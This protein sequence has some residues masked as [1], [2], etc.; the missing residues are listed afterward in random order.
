MDIHMKSTDPELIEV[1]AKEGEYHGYETN[2]FRWPKIGEASVN[3][4]APMS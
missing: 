1:W 3:G 4:M 2:G